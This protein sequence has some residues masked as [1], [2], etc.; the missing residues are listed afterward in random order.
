VELVERELERLPTLES[1]EE[2]GDQVM[3]TPRVQR[4]LQRAH[5]QADQLGDSRVGTAHLLL[6]IAAEVDAPGARALTSLGVTQERVGE[7]VVNL[8]HP[9]DG[10]PHERQAPKLKVEESL[11][12]LEAAVA[13][14]RAQTSAPPPMGGL[15]AELE[16]AQQRIAAL[17]RQNRYLEELL[18]ITQDTLSSTR[19]L[20][21][22]A[23]QA[24]VRP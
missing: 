12:T 14:L 6:A 13:E 15:Q 20:L 3:V 17:E 8:R 7:A 18:K 22:Q 19:G 5:A 2:P 23:V 4:L 1:Q 9:I 11:A 16:Q 21:E 24:R 10:V